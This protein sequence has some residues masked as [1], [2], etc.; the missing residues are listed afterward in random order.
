MTT[1][2]DLLHFRIFLL[3]VS[4]NRLNYLTILSISLSSIS[5]LYTFIIFVKAISLQESGGAEPSQPPPLPLLYANYDPI[6][7]S[8]S[9]TWL[10][11]IS[12]VYL[13]LL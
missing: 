1:P 3:S 12:L 6:Y 13:N 5:F 10:R 11:L 2:F 8:D 9:S 7:L 4:R